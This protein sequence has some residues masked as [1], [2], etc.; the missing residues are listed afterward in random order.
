MV[1]GGNP[2]SIVDSVTLNASTFKTAGNLNSNWATPSNAV[3]AVSETIQPASVQYMITLAAS[4]ATP[5][6]SNTVISARGGV[7]SLHAYPIK[8]KNSILKPILTKSAPFLINTFNAF[9][10]LFLQPHKYKKTETMRILLFIFSL[11]LSVGA[12]AQEKEQ[13]VLIKTSKGA[14]KIKLY[15]QTPLH[16]DNFLKL[17]EEDFYEGTSFH[18]VINQFMIQ[19][20]DPYSK[21]DSMKSKAGQG[22][23]GYTIP[24]EII[25][26]LIHKK[27]AL[28]AARQ[29]DAVNPKKE[30][31]GS[32]F[33][34]V[35]GKPFLVND[36]QAM[37]DQKNG[38]IK[39]QLFQKFLQDP[40]HADYQK[41]LV[42]FQNQKDQ[43]GLTDLIAELTP[44]IDKQF[45]ALEYKYSYSHGAMEIYTSQGGAPHLDG[46]YTVF[47]EVVEGLDIVDDIANVDVAPGDK[48]VV[49]II[50][51]SM[52][53][54]KK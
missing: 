36:V 1:T 27:G 18:R 51:E 11:L 52:K 48:P 16:R 12:I 6:S 45:E 38:A 54:V 32:Q 33:Y 25:D 49:G 21:I 29:P 42:A 5:K 22:G 44:I 28:A 41:R 10:I 34:I 4:M 19:G 15:N 43:K 2:V 46:D 37:V 23:P 14:I 7:S 3:V 13:L 20:G 40:A 26:S 17:V 39:Q 47:G 50:I 31:S 9:K 30:S 35:H 8:T 24:A 53:V